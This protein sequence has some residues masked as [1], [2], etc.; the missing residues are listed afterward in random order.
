MKSKAHS[1]A[2]LGYGRR[3]VPLLNS[4]KLTIAGLFILCVQIHAEANYQDHVS[5]SIKNG[6]LETVLK[7]IRKQTGYFYSF[8][9]QWKELGHRID[10]EV[11]NMPVLDA[12][13]LCFKGQPFTFAIVGKTIIVKGKDEASQEKKI[14]AATGGPGPRAIDVK[15]RVTNQQGE[16]LIGASVQ[17]KNGHNGTLTNDKGLFELKGIP[18]DA[19][20]AISYAGYREKEVTIEEGRMISVQ[21]IA[22]NDKLDE[23]QVIAYGTVLKRLNPGDVTTI[24][25]GDIEKEPVANPL[26]ALQGR[27]A[28]VFVTQS[29]GLPGSG[30]SVQI[31]GQN[32]ISNGNDPLYIVDGVP[33]TGNGSLPTLTT[34]LGTSSPNSG[35]GQ[36]VFGSPFSYLNPADIESIDVLKDADATAI[37]GSRGA[38]GV[39][40][41]TTKKG[42]SGQTRT[43][44][45]MQEGFGKV[46]NKMKLLNTRQY[47]EMRREAFKNDGALPNPNTDYD[48]TLW[49]TSRN[50]DWQ[51]ELIGGTAKY[52][53]LQGKV[54]GGNGNTQFLIGTGYHRETTVF[55]GDF[56]DVK[57]S[58]HFS[59]NNASANQKFKIQLSGLYVSDNNRLSGYDLTQQALQLAPDAPAIYNPDGS[60]NWAVNSAGVS[61]WPNHNPAAMLL[62]TYK[63]QTDNLISNAVLSYQLLPGLDLKSSFGY[64]NTQTHEVQTIP[65][66]FNEPAARSAAQRRA[67]FNDNNNRSWLIEPQLTYTRKIA[68]GVLSAIGGT[69]IQ[70][71]TSNGQLLKASGFNSDLVL[72]DILA[73]TTVTAVSSVNDVYKYNAGFGRINYNWDD[74]YIVNLTGRRDGSSRFGPANQ[75]H[76][77]GAVGAAWIFSKE[78][79][80]QRKFSFLSFG[81]LRSSFG[82]TGSDQVGDY[83][84]MDLYTPVSVGVPYQ[85][86]TG[87]A[88]YTIY[89]PNLSWEE[90]RKLEGGLELGFLKDRILLNGS[91]YQNRSSNELVGYLLPSTAGFTSVQKNLGAVVENKGWEFELRTVNVK[92]KE[93]RWTSAFNLSINRNKLAS[94]APGLDAFYQAKIGHPLRSVFVYRFLGVDPFTGQYQVADSKGNPTISP[95]PSTDASVLVDV[96]PRFYGGF[97]N[98]ISY[99]G[100]QL[101]FLFQFESR[102]KA[103]NYFYASQIP[104]TFNGSFGGNQP[105]DFLNRWQQPGDVKPIQRFSQNLST[106]L[107]YSNAQQSDQVYSDGSFIRLKNVSLSWQIPPSYQKKMHLQNLRIYVQGQNLLTITRFKGLDPETGSGHLPPLRVITGGMQVTL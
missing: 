48:L 23:V 5:L 42:R 107:S 43:D 90:T 93:V 65:L 67:S 59:I 33:Y 14:E 16:L 54:S 96:S 100:V 101:D 85:G 79:W 6:T 28:G 94:G 83:T 51:K 106:S 50:T 95:N 71:M 1:K 25:A 57:G 74:K 38:N 34:I 91:F 3:F 37:Y 81:K 20:L 11:S 27:A 12:L 97:E 7:E 13:N 88:P 92:T 45:N 18:V 9:D 76:N 39:V 32:S 70:R 46:A 29:T 64:T 87:S 44:I 55:P 2:P 17:V 86:A 63:S 49:D 69:T 35:G 99:K 62:L 80:V 30:V 41:I 73:A 52:T 58:V 102:P 22:S 82:T 89:T 8:Q 103:L 61:T 66:V 10:I 4:I 84:F 47:L 56:A 68:A 21:L 15:G 77:F 53:D 78:D 36:A 75:F 40:L 104:G 24:K 19:T 98:G 72:E 26:L 60:I 105:A 31:R